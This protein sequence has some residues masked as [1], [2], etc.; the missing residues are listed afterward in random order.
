MQTI[1]T[2]DSLQKR[3]HSGPRWCSLCSNNL[4]TT[5]HI[6]G[7]C[8]FFQAI[9]ANICSFL[10]VSATWENQNIFDNFTSILDCKP[11]HLDVLIAILWS[12]WRMQNI[13]T[14]QNGKPDRNTTVSTIIRWLHSYDVLKQ[15]P[16]SNSQI[17]MVLWP[18][19]TAPSREVYVVLEC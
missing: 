1:L 6:F 7:E 15:A 19:F 18:F 14:F 9:W 12:V 2:W 16:H 4:E 17:S 8:T 10:S 13:I 11:F 5:N 3:I